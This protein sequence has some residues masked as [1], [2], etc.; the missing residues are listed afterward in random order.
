MRTS[1][2]RSASGYE[3]IRRFIDQRL[4]GPA[5]TVGEIA[6]AAASIAEAASGSGMDELRLII[7]LREDKVE[8]E[9]RPVHPAA[10]REAAAPP[11]GSFAAW[12]LGHLSERHLSHEAAARLIGVSVK[13]VS[14]WVR[15]ET[16][17]R[18]RDLRRLNDA[19][20]D[21][22]PLGVARPAGR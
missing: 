17:P 3:E 14:R 7:T 22:P 19:F 21:L 15:S 11:E 1:V 18:M 5:P 13:T 8:I 4:S 9:L 10:S 16:E 20:G 6:S 12:L 2:A